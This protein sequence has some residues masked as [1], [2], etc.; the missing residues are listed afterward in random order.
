MAEEKQN[1]PEFEKKE[2]TYR[3]RTIED[4]KKL[5]IREFSK[6]LKSNERRTVLRQFNELQKFISEINKKT[7][8]IKK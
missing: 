1:A 2:I 7:L 4:L 3:G 6:L 8:R 5:D